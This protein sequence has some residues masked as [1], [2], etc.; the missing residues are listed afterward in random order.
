M[1]SSR[2]WSVRGRRVC[3]ATRGEARVV[4]SMSLLVTAACSVMLDSAM[5]R[6]RGAAPAVHR[7]ASVPTSPTRASLVACRQDKPQRSTARNHA[8]K[9]PPVWASGNRY[10]APSRQRR[11]RSSR[12]HS[13]IGR[14]DL[15]PWARRL[16]ACLRAA[17]EH[18][19]RTDPG[20]LS[21]ASLTRIV[22][23][24]YAAELFSTE[25]RLR[26]CCGSLCEPTPAASRTRHPVVQTERISDPRSLR[27]SFQHGPEPTAA[28]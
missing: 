8:R 25:A 2:E 17:R 21:A 4:A 12:R 13:T 26:R 5:A 23:E 9:T 6:S 11:D 15:F 3:V 7:A 27:Q 22:A 19:V 16:K 28:G 18:K 24:R 10:T 1:D 20:A 14:S